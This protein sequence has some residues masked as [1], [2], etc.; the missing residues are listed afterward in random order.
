MQKVEDLEM[1]VVTFLKIREQFTF[2]V[3]K[4]RSDAGV[5]QS[6]ET[7]TAY[8]YR[9]LALQR[10]GAAVAAGTWRL[11]ALKGLL[12]R[13]A[14]DGHET[15]RVSRLSDETAGTVGSQKRKR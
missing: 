6:G 7:L 3:I 8:A 2:C 14:P 11:I 1:F 5:H 15:R 13:Q 9:C 10:N 12:F 4:G